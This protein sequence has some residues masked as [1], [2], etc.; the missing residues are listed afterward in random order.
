MPV[1]T[2]A[3]A[4]CMGR[5]GRGWQQGEGTSGREGLQDAA[6]PA[7]V[8][9]G[10][11]PGGRAGNPTSRNLCLTLGDHN[12][13]ARRSSTQLDG[14]L[15]QVEPEG[16]TQYPLSAFGVRW[17]GGG[18]GEE[19]RL[20]RC[21]QRARVRGGEESGTACARGTW[22]GPRSLWVRFSDPLGGAEGVSWGRPAGPP[23]VPTGSHA[24]SAASRAHGEQQVPS[25]SRQVWGGPALGDP[26]GLRP[27]C[28]GVQQAGDLVS[29]AVKQRR[30]N[31]GREPREAGGRSR[32]EARGWGLQIRRSRAVGF[33]AASVTSEFCD[34]GLLA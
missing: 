25:L 16:Q 24:A 32:P 13:R 33:G 3:P 18:A 29:V 10:P 26:A 31:Q 1:G 9:T 8:K 15:G 11:N 12:A 19:T 34:L 20:L 23:G 22:A 21:H 17:S 7:K 28:S 14:G 6:S 2:A 27:F 4:P 30:D 5:R